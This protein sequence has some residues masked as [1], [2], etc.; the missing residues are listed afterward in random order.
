MKASR[1]ASTASSTAV[2]PE[3]AA[4]LRLVVNRLA[5]RLRGQGRENLSHSLLSALITI[6]CHG[7]LTLGRLA[8]R[9]LVKPPSVTRSVAEL[10]ERGL[11]RRETDPAD[12]RIARVTITA[13]GRRT[14]RRARTRKTAY[15]A[16]RLRTLDAAELEIIRQAVPLLERLLEDDR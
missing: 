9:E 4:S 13:E 12:H 2:D 3:L 7:P 10:E 15:L 1:T 14:V 16:E 6:E 11:V 5:R 8:E